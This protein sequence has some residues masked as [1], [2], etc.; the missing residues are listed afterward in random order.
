METVQLPII[1]NLYIFERIFCS[2]G[3]WDYRVCWKISLIVLWGELTHLSEWGNLIN[4]PLSYSILQPVNVRELSITF[5]RGF[6]QYAFQYSTFPPRRV[7]F[8]LL[9]ISPICNPMSL[10]IISTKRHFN[11]TEY[12]ILPVLPCKKKTEIIRANQQPSLKVLLMTITKLQ[13]YL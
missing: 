4:R 8:S 7:D 12:P 1:Q 9:F 2:Q 3:R 10:F 11:N 5:S 6:N 13:G